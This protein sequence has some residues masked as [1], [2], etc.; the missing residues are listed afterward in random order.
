MFA[1]PAIAAIGGSA[2]AAG[3]AGLVGS[4]ALGGVQAYSQYQQ[5]KAAGKAA[6][7]NA[8][9]LENQK[10][11]Q[12]EKSKI[13]LHRARY[14]NE[15]QFSAARAQAGASGAVFSGSQLD[16]FEELA[17][18]QELGLVDAAQSAQEAARQNEQQQ[19]LTKFQGDLA[20]S[21]GRFSAFGTLLN[22]TTSTVG[23][24]RAGKYQGI[25]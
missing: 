23:K 14:N 15:R 20:R 21:Q 4:A 2:S 22:T 19:S 11:A 24:Y 16:T 25:F 12:L 3:T 6:N 13:A 7:Q 17:T 5:G 9:V 18:N 1:L 10:Q 8:K